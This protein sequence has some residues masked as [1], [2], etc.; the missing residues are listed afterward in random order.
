PK[1]FG[2]TTQFRNLSGR[3]FLLIKLTLL[4]LFKTNKSFW[5]PKLS[6]TLKKIEMKIC[7]ALI[8]FCLILHS[9]FSQ[10]KELKPRVFV[11]TDIENEPDDAQ[12]LVRFMTYSNQMEI[13]GIVA[14][15]SCWQ[16]NKTAE[17]RILEI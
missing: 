5:L 10:S 2:S 12:S 11:L 8:S 9:G 4:Y 17:W 14:T 1:V 16:R 15:T 3:A 6:L 7:L 13:E